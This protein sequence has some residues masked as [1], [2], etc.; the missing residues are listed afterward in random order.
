[1]LIFCRTPLRFPGI[2]DRNVSGFIGSSIAR[3]ND[4]PPRCRDC[5]DVAVWCWKSSS[6]NFGHHGQFSIVQCSI[7]VKCRCQVRGMKKVMRLKKTPVEASAE[8]VTEPPAEPPAK[9]KK[10]IL[11]KMP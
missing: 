5:G 4:K 2:N 8:P 6:G 11:K 7:N 9:P 3:R 10:K 1:M